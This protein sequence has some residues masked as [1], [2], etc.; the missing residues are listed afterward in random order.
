M[1]AVLGQEHAAQIEKRLMAFHRSNELSRRLMEV[2]TIGPVGA[3][4]WVTKIV[5]PHAFRSGRRCAAWL[6]LTPKDHST[7]GKQRHGGI[8]RAGDESLRATLVSGATVYIRHVRSGRH[9]AF[10][11]AGRAARAQAAEAGGRGAGQQDRPDHL[12]AH[13][14]RR[15]IRP[16]PS[17]GPRGLDASPY[18]EL[19]AAPLGPSSDRVS[20]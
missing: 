7:A 13:D 18:G 16:C 17:A 8:T 4:L 9:H 19:R 3:C 2:P 20:T 11:V 14:L 15:T 12:E 10:A 6:G 5:D 1:F